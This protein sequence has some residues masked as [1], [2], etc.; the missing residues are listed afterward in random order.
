[1]RTSAVYQHSPLTGVGGYT[2]PRP[3]YMRRIDADNAARAAEW[4]VERKQE[5]NDDLNY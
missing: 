5:K 1:M 2:R 3:S 4:E